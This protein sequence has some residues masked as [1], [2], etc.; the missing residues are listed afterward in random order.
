MKARLIIT[1]FAMLM[2]VG[3]KAQATA[4]LTSLERSKMMSRAMV[5]MEKATKTL[6]DSLGIKP[7]G[8]DSVTFFYNYHSEQYGKKEAMIERQLNQ[9]VNAYDTWHGAASSSLSWDKRDAGIPFYKIAIRYIDDK[10]RNKTATVYNGGF[11]EGRTMTFI[12]GDKKLRNFSLFYQI[13]RS[14]ND[15]D[16]TKFSIT[17]HITNVKGSMHHYNSEGLFAFESK[18]EGFREFK[19]PEKYDYAFDELKAKLLRLNRTYKNENKYGKNAVL[20][21]LHK[22]SEGYTEKLTLGQ[23]AEVKSILTDWLKSA[24]KGNHQR[25]V[26]YAMAMFESKADS[27]KMPENKVHLYELSTSSRT[28]TIG[29]RY[30]TYETN[31]INDNEF[32]ELKLRGK[33]S[34]DAKSVEIHRTIFDRDEIKLEGGNRNFKLSRNY[35]R[36]EIIGIESIAFDYLSF[37]NDGKPVRIDLEKGR[38]YGS[39]LNEK[40][41]RYERQLTGHRRKLRTTKTKAEHDS[42]ENIVDSIMKQAINDNLDNPISA[43]YLSKTYTL[44]DEERLRW[45][46]SD[47]YP[48]ANHPALSPVRQYLTKKELRKP[49]KMFTDFTS[50][51]YDNNKFK[52]S[53]FAG[54]GNYVLLDFRTTELESFMLDTK[55][56]SSLNKKYAKKGLYIVSVWLEW[57]KVGWSEKI[58]KRSYDWF[59][60]CEGHLFGDEAARAY[61][62]NELPQNVLIGP[63]GR[64]VASDISSEK[65]EKTIDEI[66][67]ARLSNGMLLRDGGTME[68]PQGKPQQKAV[69]PAVE[70]PKEKKVPLTTQEVKEGDVSYAERLEFYVDKVEHELENVSDSL[71]LKRMRKIIAADGK[72]QMIVNK[73]FL[74]SIENDN[75]PQ[76][77]IETDQ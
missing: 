53:H 65:L 49:G 22:M 72:L 20:V 58:R 59:Q 29:N 21:A 45:F 17:L 76:E 43:F 18:P 19:V 4:V 26:S 15:K 51:D 16:K 62:I 60:V 14:A 35:A 69:Q 77:I 39:A 13:W 30:V 71:Y 56:L 37:I 61:G 34:K 10:G 36:D 27:T 44:Y 40:L 57:D 31:D 67:A 6:I 52:L 47:E 25:V 74:K 73:I 9:L 54:R 24:D 28:T 1:A 63:D 8:S 68:Q 2:T 5:E 42:I 75:Q 3:V 32:V 7:E 48:Y 12:Y 33:A 46:V 38:V 70:E 41:N 55:I 23:T 64:I 11:Y 50:H 66:F